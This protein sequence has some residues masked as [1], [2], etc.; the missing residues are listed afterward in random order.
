[1]STNQWLSDTFDVIVT[2]Q[3]NRVTQSNCSWYFTFFTYY[4]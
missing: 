3:H 4:K 1:M 2:K